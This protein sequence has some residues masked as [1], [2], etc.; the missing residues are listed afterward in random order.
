MKKIKTTIMVADQ[1]I[2]YC[3]WLNREVEEVAKFYTNIFKNARLKGI[4][5]NPDDT[6][7]GNSEI[8]LSTSFEIEGQT[9]LALNGGS[10]DTLNPSISFFIHSDS[11]EEIDELWQKFSEDGNV[12]MA[13]NKYPFS[14]KYGWIQDKYGLSWQLMLTNPRNEKRPKLMPSLMFVNHNY[15][16][17][18]EAISFYTSLFKES[19][20]GTIERYPAG[21]EPEQEG[22]I[23]YADF[24]LEGTWFA[25]M[26]SAHDHKFDFNQAMSFV[27][28]CDTQEEVDHYWYK[29]SADGGTEIHGGWLKDKY[30][31]TWQIVPKVLVKLM[32]GEDR[33][34]AN[35]VMKAMMKMVKL[36]IKMLE[37]A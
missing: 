25:L 32:A 22:R 4:D 7:S 35:R 5:R 28:L 26:E 34:K 1:K 11:P 23:M 24:R 29:L 17:A 33:E 8:V 27:V 18:E 37:E 15:G 6:P 30:G 36:D 2:S 9:F 31:V 16:K 21:M 3:L 19:K 14:D 13:L 20:T 10:N 12:L